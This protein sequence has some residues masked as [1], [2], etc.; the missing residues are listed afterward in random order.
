MEKATAPSTVADA[1]VLMLMLLY[2]LM[3]RMPRICQSTWILWSD[4]SASHNP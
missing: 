3:V 2:M 1:P 4:G